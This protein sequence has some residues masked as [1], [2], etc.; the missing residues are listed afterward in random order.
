MNDYYKATIKKVTGKTLT[1]WLTITNPDVR[2]FPLNISSGFLILAQYFMEFAHKQAPE[3]IRNNYSLIVDNDWAKSVKHKYI[4]SFNL[5]S[6]L[7]FP[8]PKKVYK[9]KGDD[10][11]AWWENETNLPYAE[12]KLEVNDPSL[13]SEMSVG[14]QWNVSVYE[15]DY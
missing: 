4:K 3:E 15:L 11:R 6:K 1:F 14:D 9:L 8:V 10:F 13:L 7:N 2:I 5:I 12:Y